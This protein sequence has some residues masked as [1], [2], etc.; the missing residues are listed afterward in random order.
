[1][2]AVTVSRPA[3]S[4][5]DPAADASAAASGDV[6]DLAGRGADRHR[7]GGEVDHGVSDDRG[8]AE[9]LER[10]LRLVRERRRK[11]C[12]DAVGGLDEEHARAAS[13]DR[14]EVAAQAVAGE[15][16]DLAGHLDPG[17]APAD[18]HEREPA[19]A[20][21]VVGFDLGSL[22][23]GEDPVADV[24]R[25]GERLQ[26]RRVWPPVVVPEV[27]VLRSAGNDQCVV[28]ERCRAP[29]VR[30]VIE[31]DLPSFEIEAAHLRQHHANVRLALKDRT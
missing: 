22:E 5:C 30:E 26:L 13:V 11:A 27:G 2:S 10:A 7:V 23:R 9:L 25:A 19:P 1:M 16:G 21:F 8:D 17:W 28:V 18:D 24:E 12:E 20:P 31:Y 14:V 4:T 6:L 29:T 3:R 15:F